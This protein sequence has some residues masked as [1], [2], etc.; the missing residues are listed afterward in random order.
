MATASQACPSLVQEPDP[1]GNLYPETVISQT[2]KAEIHLSPLIYSFHEG[3][4]HCWLRVFTYSLF[5]LMNP[6]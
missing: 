4:P 3:L 6:L 2:N 1:K 5:S